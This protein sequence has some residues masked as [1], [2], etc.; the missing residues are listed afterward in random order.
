MKNNFNSF[1]TKTQIL[2]YDVNIPLIRFTL[3]E[4]M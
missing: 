2:E 3:E 4:R 1:C